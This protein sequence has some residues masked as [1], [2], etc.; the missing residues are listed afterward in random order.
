MKEKITLRDVSIKKPPEM[1]AKDIK[2]LRWELGMTQK[3]FA[4]A[5][6][7]SKRTIEALEQGR[8]MAKGAVLRLLQIFKEYPIFVQGQKLV[9]ERTPCSKREA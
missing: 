1:T 4:T 7:L 6:G 3:R 2:S 5:M 9:K 8:Y